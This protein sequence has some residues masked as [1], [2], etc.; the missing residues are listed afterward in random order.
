MPAKPPATPKPRRIRNNGLP[1]RRGAEPGARQL[2]HEPNEIT[3]EVVRTHAAVGTPQETVAYMLGITVPTLTKYYRDELAHGLAIANGMVGSVLWAKAMAGDPA[4]V[5]FWMKTRAGYRESQ[6]HRHTLGLG[7]GQDESE[8]PEG[9]ASKGIPVGIQVTFVRAE[10][11][12]P[13]K[14]E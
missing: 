10:A 1:D 6:N 2:S 8:V 7:I 12:A 4:S 14:D 13:A 5:F 11:K 9:D 3:R